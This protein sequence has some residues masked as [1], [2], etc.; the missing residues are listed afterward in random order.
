MDS[1]VA[2]IV[3]G[4]IFFP[5]VFSTIRKCLPLLFPKNNIASEASCAA[6]ALRC[7]SIIQALLAVA[8]GFNIIRETHQDV[9]FSRCLLVDIYCSFGAPYM[10]YDVG[11]MYIVHRKE[12]KLNDVPFRTAV[13]SFL[14]EKWVLV[15]HHIGLVIIF[16]PFVMFLRNGKGDFFIGCFF[17]A[18]LSTPAINI[19]IILIKLNLGDTFFFRINNIAYLVSFF[20]CRILLF[21]FLYWAYAVNKG[22]SIDETLS[23]MRAICHIG[24]AALLAMQ[25]MWFYKFLRVVL[26]DRN[27]RV[28]DPLKH[29][30]NGMQENN[31]PPVRSEGKAD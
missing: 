27:A 5:S 20:I 4:S 31:V 12:R 29:N 25:V 17:L 15:A 28:L 30:G 8:V 1:Y 13:S 18:E 6:I 21:P 11:A 24:C 7:T 2:W 14:K 23:S 16:Y 22:L 26:R 10:I 9:I 3:A 19:R